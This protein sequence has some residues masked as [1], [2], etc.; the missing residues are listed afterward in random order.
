MISKLRI[1]NGL[2]WF[3]DKDRMYF[4]DSSSDKVYRSSIPAGDFVPSK[5]D[6]FVAIQNGAPDGAVT[7]VAG[8]YWSVMWGAACVRC[9]LPD[10]EL[11]QEFALSAPQPTCVAFGDLEGNLMFVASARAGLDSGQ[12]SVHPKSGSLFIFSTDT[13]GSRN[14]RYISKNG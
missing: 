11:L 5:A 10:A 2:A 4:S 6:V 12:L 9:Y 7:D 14:F 8:R 1:S 3:P 13:C